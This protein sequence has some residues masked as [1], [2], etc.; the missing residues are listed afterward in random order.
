MRR[1]LPPAARRYFAIK[2]ES[3]TNTGTTR[4]ASSNLARH[5]RAEHDLDDG[6]D[7]LLMHLGKQRREGT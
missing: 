3:L 2:G 4:T 6:G 5:G 1:P 7:A